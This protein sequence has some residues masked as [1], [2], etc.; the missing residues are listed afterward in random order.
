MR[1]EVIRAMRRQSDERARLESALAAAQQLMSP[2][3]R[4]PADSDKPDELFDLTLETV[5]HNEAVA[6][7]YAEV[8]AQATRLAQA[9]LAVAEALHS[10]LPEMNDKQRE[11]L[12]RA[13]AAVSGLHAPRPADPL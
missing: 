7:A 4:L 8:A 9:S 1:D 2:T 11:T 3:G 6:H 10:D 13:Q 5:S 12:R